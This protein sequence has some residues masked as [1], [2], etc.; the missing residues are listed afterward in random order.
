MQLK[1][2]T[3]TYF[4]AF[5]QA[6]FEFQPGMNL[7]VGINGVGKS[8]VLDAIRVTLSRILPAVKTSR[9]RPIKF[10]SSDVKVGNDWFYASLQFS[11]HNEVTGEVFEEEYEIRERLKAQS[12][13]NELD[14]HR[15]NPAALTK[16]NSEE[17][18]REYLSR[19]SKTLKEFA[20][21]T[22]PPL[23]V[24][25][26]TYRSLY[27]PKQSNAR[28]KAAAFA[29]AL[30]NDRGL[31]L[32]EFADWWLVQEALATE[33]LEE[34]YKHRLNV[35]NDAIT[36]FLNGCSN[37]RSVREPIPTLLIDKGN[38]VLDLRQL[39]DGERS[40]IA[41]VFD[42]ARRLALA[43]PNLPDPL[44]DGKAVVLIDELDLHLHP[45][46]QRDIVAKLTATFP[47]CQFIA[48]THSPQ[49]V[50]EVS[51][52]SVIL[53]ENGAVFRPNQ[54]LGMDSN[55]V[56]QY[57]MG[58]GDRNP[59]IDKELDHISDLLEDENFEQAEVAINTVRNQ[60][61]DF[62]AL[63]RLQTKLDRLQLL[64]L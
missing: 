32:R 52:S 26:S 61:G 2:L 7:L 23:G 33:T 44:R 57:L 56:L 47:N 14:R 59:E 36:T 54:S 25:F 51:P 41:M 46:W 20:S 50:G 18:R 11:L 49:I 4:R 5:D 1:R 24:F 45:R 60:I 22:M 34:E 38:S 37:L 53:I 21:V 6:E 9:N 3:L 39:S 55:W 17:Q 35:M 40:M 28:G 30:A 64:G 63:V 27:S 10:T 31:R 8:T 62:P 15:A 19:R 48:T 13:I 42:L 16:L 29:D 43:N 12:I 58:T